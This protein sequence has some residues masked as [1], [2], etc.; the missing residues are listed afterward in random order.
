MELDYFKPP[1]FIFWPLFITCQNFEEICKYV[2]LTVCP[3][4]CLFVCLSFDNSRTLWHIITKLDPH[5]YPWPVQKWQGER[6]SSDLDDVLCTISMPVVY[7]HNQIHCQ[8]KRNQRFISRF[9]RFSLF[10]WKWCPVCP[11][12]FRIAPTAVRKVE[13]GAPDHSSSHAATTQGLPL[14]SPQWFLPSSHV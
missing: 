9:A 4:V 6:T 12:P 7:I 10:W 11:W 5:M 1:K 8:F 13:R 3:F 2:R 14:T